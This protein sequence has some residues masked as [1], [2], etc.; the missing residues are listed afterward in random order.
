MFHELGHATGH[1]S[2]LNRHGMETGI[3]PFGSPTYSREE[4]VA[5]FTAA[6]LCNVSG[7][8]NTIDN[9]AA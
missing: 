9:S 5:E 7:I 3:A 1:E 2:R 8:E 6:F 4:L